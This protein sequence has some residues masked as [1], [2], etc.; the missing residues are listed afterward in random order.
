MVF[1][2]VSTGLKVTEKSLGVGPSFTIQQ[3]E[4]T[5]FLLIYL[6]V[7]WSAFSNEEKRGQ[8]CVPIVVEEC[9]SITE[10]CLTL[11][12]HG[13]QHAMILNPSPSPRICSNSCLLC[14]WLHPTTSS[15]IRHFSSYPQSLQHQLLFQSVGCMHQVAKVLE[16]KFQHQSF[17]C[18]FRVDFL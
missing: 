12:S 18:I 1:L 4:K 5:S 11:G 13:L 3:R 17:Q 8:L 14:Q 10:F 6:F 2:I 9:C 15:S 16:P 7:Q